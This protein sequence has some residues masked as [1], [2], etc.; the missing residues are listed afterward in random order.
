MAFVTYFYPGKTLNRPSTSLATAKTGLRFTTP[1]RLSSRMCEKSDG[2]SVSLDALNSRRSK[3][4]E[5]SSTQVANFAYTGDET[6]DTRS[7]SQKEIDRLRAA[8]KFIAIDEGRFEC[9][10]CGNIYNP[11]E[12]DRQ[13]GIAPDTPFEDIP[14]SYV[15]PV[16]R[17]PKN[18][19]V[20]KK[21]IIAGFAD[22][23]KYGF[24]S[25]TMTGDQK[26]LII[27]GSLV[28]CFLLLLS[29]YALN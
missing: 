19:F 8:E 27:Y 28:F 17:S 20:S 4:A 6:E 11:A 1:R 25:N 21:K 13:A 22:N 14:D 26:S 10:A 5:E 23:Q 3:D 16:C 18:R 7:E 2:E 24:G 12:G 9:T 29:G 15:C